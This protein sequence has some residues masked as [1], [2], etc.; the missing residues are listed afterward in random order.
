MHIVVIRVVLAIVRLLLAD[1]H[2]AYHIE[3]QFKLATALSL[4]VVGHRTFELSFGIVLLVGY[5]LEKGIRMA[6]LI[7]DITKVHQNHNGLLIARNRC[8]VSE[9]TALNTLGVHLGTA[10]LCLFNNLLSIDSYIDTIL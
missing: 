7:L 6:R 2:R 8:G 1:R 5:L 4:E 10:S 9:G 3:V